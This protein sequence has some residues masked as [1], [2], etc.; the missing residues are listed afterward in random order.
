MSI[1]AKELAQKLNVS[2]ATISMVLNHKSGIS[3]ATREKV[4]SGAREY[5]FDLSKYYTFTEVPRSICFLIY[6]KSGQVVTDTPFFSELTEGIS[7]TCKGNN[8]NLSIDYIYGINP[9]APQLK[10]I[11]E[12]GYDCLLLLATEMEI[13]DFDSFLDLNCPLMVLDCYYDELQLDAVLI[14]NLQGAYL[15]T[16]HLAQQGISEIGYLKSSVR[17]AN[18]KERADGYYK[19]LR[20][21]SIKE[22]S[23]YVLELSPSM[24]GA[25]LDMKKLIAQNIPLAKAYFAD[26]DLIASGAMR[27]FQEAG[28]QVPEDIS[29]I[30]FDDI[31]ICSFLSPPLSTM[32]VPKHNLGVLAITQLINKLNNPDRTPIKIELSPT[33]TVRKSVKTSKSN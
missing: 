25:Y 9:I 11:S 7:T 22:N 26:N 13:Q 31:P 29:L 16:C 10:S 27:A 6:K 2:T 18:F 8:I 12:K 4:L 24:E 30:G 17:I 5:G 15:A 1:S 23:N 33:L 3:P 20:H 28:I 14:N 32:H 19:A 21:H